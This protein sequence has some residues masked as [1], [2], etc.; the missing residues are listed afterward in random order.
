MAVEHDASAGTNAV[1]PR[2]HVDDLGR[3]GMQFDLGTGDMRPDEIRGERR[4]RARVA[5]RIR[6]WRRDQRQCQ[7][8]DLTDPVAR[9]RLASCFNVV[10]GGLPKSVSNG[11]AASR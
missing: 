11:S 4:D 1:D 8:Q 10:Q 3:T 9:D 5:F 6:R 7:A 2:H